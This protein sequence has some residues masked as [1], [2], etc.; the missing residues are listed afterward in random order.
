MDRANRLERYGEMV[1]L[2][3]PI[4]VLMWALASVSCPAQE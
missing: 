2:L 4:E 1:K 3:S